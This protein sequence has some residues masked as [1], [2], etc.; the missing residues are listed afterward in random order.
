MKKIFFALSLLL[1]AF[2]ILSLVHFHRG[3][4]D[5]LLTSQSNPP[6]IDRFTS[7]ELWGASLAKTGKNAQLVEEEKVKLEKDKFLDLFFANQ[8][9]ATATFQLLIDSNH[10]FDRDTFVNLVVSYKSDPETKK[11]IPFPTNWRITDGSLQEKLFNDQITKFGSWIDFLKT[12][13]TQTLTETD[14]DDN[15]FFWNQ[16]SQAYLYFVGLTDKSKITPYSNEIF[17]LFL[18]NLTVRMI[19]AVGE[20]MPALSSTS[21]FQYIPGVNPTF[22]GEDRVDL[23]AIWNL[24]LNTFTLKDLNPNITRTI[25]NNRGYSLYNKNKLNDAYPD[26]IKLLIELTE[27]NNFWTILNRVLN[28]NLGIKFLFLNKERNER[29]DLANLISS[30]SH[31][32]AGEIEL[33]FENATNQFREELTK[34]IFANKPGIEHGIDNPDKLWQLFDETKRKL[35]IDLKIALEKLQEVDPTTTHL[36]INGGKYTIDQL[37]QTRNQL[38]NDQFDQ[39][40]ITQIKTLFSNQIYASDITKAVDQLAKYREISTFLTKLTTDQKLTAL[41][42]SNQNYSFTS[43]IADAKKEFIDLSKDSFTKL[44]NLVDQDISLKKLETAY[45]ESLPYPQTQEPNASTSETKSPTKKSTNQNLAIGLGTAGGVVALAG[46]GGFV[47]WFV[48]IRKS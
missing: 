45:Q 13:T 1:F 3:G 17:L 14:A 30:F 18:E 15:N 7:D 11:T 39:K 41:K 38:L 42:I 29:H 34:L 48:K 23:T 10:Y 20:I 12:A 8:D 43:L 33:N 37:L 36:P 5:K 44:Q 16:F 9:K 32:D 35:L 6:L 27:Q 26:S 4:G 24:D 40:A 46:V 28:N 22:V 31:Y 47:Y 25:R 19:Q 21:F 2:P